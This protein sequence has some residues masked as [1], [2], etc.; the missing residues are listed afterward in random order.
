MENLQEEFI[1]AKTDSK[2]KVN[3][4]RLIHEKQTDLFNTTLLTMKTELIF[5]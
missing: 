2:D 1:V 4:I 3:R 5:E